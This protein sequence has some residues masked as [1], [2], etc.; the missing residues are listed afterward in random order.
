MEREIFDG[1][2]HGEGLDL[3][4]RVGG[5]CCGCGGSASGRALLCGKRRV[6]G[7][8]ALGASKN[9]ACFGGSEFGVGYMFGS[10]G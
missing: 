5:S 3:I 10:G 4:V 1:W 8:L 6:M 7:G 2:G 9:G